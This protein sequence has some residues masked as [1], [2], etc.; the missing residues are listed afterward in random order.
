MFF[1]SMTTNPILS[2]ISRH[3]IRV[4]NI[5]NC[6]PHECSAFNVVP[7]EQKTTPFQT[8]YNEH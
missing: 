3:R 1:Q 8:T 7:S 2:L 5:R 4:S 6:I